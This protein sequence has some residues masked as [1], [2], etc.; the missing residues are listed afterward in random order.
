MMASYAI[1]MGILVFTLLMKLMVIPSYTFI[2]QTC[3][4]YLFKYNVNY[5]Y[6]LTK[7]YFIILLIKQEIVM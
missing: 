2:S 4:K 5:I 3:I 6:V 7:A 1:Y